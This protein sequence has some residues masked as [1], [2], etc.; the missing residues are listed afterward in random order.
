MHHAEL[1]VYNFRELPHAGIWIGHDSLIG[2]FSVIRGPGGVTIGDRVYL[3]PAVH[4]YSSDHMFD[5]L[6]RPFVEQ[7]VTCRGVTIE[8]DTWI[9]AAAII[10]DGVHIGRGCVVAAGAVVTKDVP[11]F[12]MVGGV[13]ARIIKQIGEVERPECV[14]S[15]GA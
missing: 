5:D 14:H 4:I 9:G 15:D 12:T 13:P 10:L 3:S 1:H 8:D 6:R 7:G 2:E 11:A